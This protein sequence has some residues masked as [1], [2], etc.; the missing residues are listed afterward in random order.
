MLIGRSQVVAAAGPALEERLQEQHGLRECQAGRCIKGSQTLE[1]EEPIGG[2]DQSGVVIPAQPGASFIVV[3][4]ELAFELPVI[5]LDL[6]A[7]P[8]QASQPLGLWCQR[9]G[10]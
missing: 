5:E 6:P 1:G 10:C 8:R 7:Q 2:G 9:G 3:E 4:P